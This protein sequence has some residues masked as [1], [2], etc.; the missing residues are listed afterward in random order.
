MDF[1][2][3]YKQ[4][5]V[6]SDKA[7]T[8]IWSYMVYV[9]LL[10]GLWVTFRL[11]FVQFRRFKDAFDV[12]IANVFRKKGGDLEGDV[13]P[14][15]ALATALAATVGNGN[16]AGVATALYWGGPGAIFWMWVCGFLGMATK[17]CEATLGIMY[18]EKHPDG[19]IAG[20]P[21]YYIKNGLKN[22]RLARYFA[23]TFAVCGAFAA[24]FGTGNMMQGN[25]ITTALN[26]QLGF[27]RVVE[28]MFASY[29]MSPASIDLLSKAIIGFV[30]TFFIGL[31]VIGGLKRISN[32]AEKIV[33]LMIVVYLGF[34]LFILIKHYDAIPAVFTLIFTYAFTPCAAV[35]GFL[36]AAV[37]KGMQFGFR[38]GLL[39][40]EAGLGSAPI[41][42]AAAQSPSPVH[43]GLIGVMEVFI[44]TII[45]CSLTGF[46]N[47]ATGTWQS[48][49]NGIEMTT[50]TFSKHIPMIGSLNL[51]G[52]IV[53]ISSLLF[54]YTTIIGWCYYGEQCAKYLFG[55][56]IT[57]PY[58]ICYVFLSYL[59]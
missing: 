16:L 25:Q 7:A 8:E 48:G 45:V 40:N 15:A 39:S 59:G 52:V 3:L 43:Q 24:L 36:G 28:K 22:K 9:L 49:L 26:V 27:S 17:Y 44:D 30:L 38:R 55:L 11:G 21:M 29:S 35:G 4:L 58:R 34:G 18:R 2:A 1:E 37:T 33:P 6:W 10:V 54:G 51:G 56:R 41:A 14:L 46:I 23:G 31:V 13:S 12:F 47:L 20:G 57:Y 32:V 50:L 53:A 19:T 42:H 5:T